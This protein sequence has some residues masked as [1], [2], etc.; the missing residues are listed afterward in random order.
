M[1]VL[2]RHR[3]INVPSI[4]DGRQWSDVIGGDIRNS[5]LLSHGFLVRYFN[6]FRRINVCLSLIGIFFIF[7]ISKCN[8]YYV[9]IIIFHLN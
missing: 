3:Q 9:A 1:D 2:G 7:L 6:F 5:I 4:W 8:V